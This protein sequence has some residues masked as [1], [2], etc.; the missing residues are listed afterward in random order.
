MAGYGH[1]IRSHNRRH[2]PGEQV[3]VLGDIEVQFVTWDTAAPMKSSAEITAPARSA[4]GCARHEAQR[5][6]WRRLSKETAVSSS[7][8]LRPRGIYGWDHEKA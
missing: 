3:K 4:A 1:P 5:K 7:M 8:L 2:G 6:E